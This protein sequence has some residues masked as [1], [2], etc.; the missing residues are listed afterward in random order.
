MNGLFKKNDVEISEVDKEVSDIIMEKVKP[1]LFKEITEETKE[2]IR[3]DLSDICKRVEINEVP[4]VI[5]AETYNGRKF[6]IEIKFESASF[7]E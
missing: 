5:T 2:T 3:N 7:I 1:Y 6:I 4:F